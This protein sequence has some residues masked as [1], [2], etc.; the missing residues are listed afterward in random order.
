VTAVRPDGGVDWD[1]RVAAAL[2]DVC[3]PCSLAAG[4][5]LSLV[6]MG[7]V[8]GS[9]FDAATGTLVVRL[10][11]T[12]PGCTFFGAYSEAARS[13]VSRLPGVRRAEVVLDTETVWHPGHLTGAGARALAE[14]RERTV[15]LSQVRPRMWQEQP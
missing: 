12:G 13:A 9:A 7:L 6:D 4:A 5:P 3:D 1:E 15:L 11:V 10:T 2:A 14:R 8:K